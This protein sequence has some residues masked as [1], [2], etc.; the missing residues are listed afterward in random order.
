MKKLL[1]IIILS[2]YLITPSWALGIRDFQIEALS[3]GESALNFF[4]KDKIKNNEKSFYRD[5]EYIPVMF[6]IKAND[7]EW[8]NFHYKKGDKNYIMDGI[9][10]GIGMNYNECMNKLKEIEQSVSNLF[11]GY[12]KETKT[13][14]PHDADITGRSRISGFKFQNP[15]GDRFTAYCDNFHK[16]MKMK[17]NLNIGVY[18]SEF[19]DWIGNKAYK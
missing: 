9:R 5:D 17:N 13:N 1:V 11:I 14:R 7:Y 16:D 12:S 6:D 18:T 8:I 2:L 4:S 19:M 10:A 3:I 15:S